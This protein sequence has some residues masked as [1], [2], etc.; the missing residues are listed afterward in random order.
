MPLPT[1]R[2]AHVDTP[3]SNILIGWFK[4]NPSLLRRVFPVAPVDKQSDK[5]FTWTRADFMRLFAQLRAPGEKPA[6]RRGRLSTDS[7]SCQERAVRQ[8]LYE[9]IE[10]GADIALRS[11]VA[12]GLARDIMM[13]ET[14]LFIDTYMKTGV[15][16]TDQAVPR[17]WKDGTSDPVGDVRKGRRTVVLDTG[18]MFQPNVLIMEDETA[19]VLVDHPD[20]RGRMP[21]SALAHVNAGERAAFLAKIFDVEEV[22][23]ITESYNVAAEQAAI[24]MKNAM[25]ASSASGRVLLAYRTKTPSI[26]EP[27][28]GY[29]FSWR[30]FDGGGAA[31]VYPDGDPGV[32]TTWL[33]ANS[34]VDAKLVSKECGYMMTGVLAAV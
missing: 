28:A 14:K 4:A 32:K 11:P 22:V 25:D 1:L 19:D 10:K 26:N 13:T 2:M 29:V 31:R 23:I 27:S 12:Q 34:Y 3:L 16:Q 6:E 18:G 9:E 5:Y 33:E 21:T 8:A 17:S 15:W 30:A 24:S 20:I 7:Y